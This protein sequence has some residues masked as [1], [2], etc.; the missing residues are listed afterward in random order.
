[1]SD[2]NEQ[3]A[4]RRAKL[5]ELRKTGNPFPNDFHRDTLA[6]DAL[7]QYGDAD[8]DRLEAEPIM[9]RVAGRLMSKRVMGKASFAH[10]QDA[11]GRIQ[12]FLQRD[13]LPEGVYNQGFKKWD[14]G[15]ILGA[16]GTLFKTR[17]GELS[18]RVELTSTLHPTLT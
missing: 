16:E 1:M 18:V 4:Q 17:T 6:A 7:R 9:V 2:D 15:D 13:Q 11:S 14:I 12:L 10:L 3:I 8:A 5:T